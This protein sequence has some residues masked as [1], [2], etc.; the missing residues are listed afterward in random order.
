MAVASIQGATAMYAVDTAP[1]LGCSPARLAWIAP[2]LLTLLAF[3]PAGFAWSA[4]GLNAPSP[5]PAA[6]ARRLGLSRGLCIVLGDLEGQIVRHLAEQTECLIYTQVPDAEDAARL[7]QEVF[8][9]G[10]YGTRVY[11]EQGPW[12]HVY[13][14]DNLADALIAVR[15]AAGMPPAEA[16]RVLRPRGQAH[17]GSAKSIKP[18]PAGVDAW[19]H[20]Y[21]GP[22][23]NPQ[24]Q[25]AI[26]RGPYLT[27]AN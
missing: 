20:P 19:S 12:D 2:R 13:L 5:E 8:A 9:A 14:A 3:F 15:D 26:A 4:E 27:Q 21:H 25:D 23:N 22:D 18:V 17:L 7:R 24:S 16:M 1:R 10:L 6:W 11:V